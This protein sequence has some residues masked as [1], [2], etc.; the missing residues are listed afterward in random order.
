MRGLLH[1]IVELKSLAPPGE[2]PAVPT[3]LESHRGDRP[4]ITLTVVTRGPHQAALERMVAG[5]ES[6]S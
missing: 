4:S 1:P 3:K 5:E 6:R 2:D